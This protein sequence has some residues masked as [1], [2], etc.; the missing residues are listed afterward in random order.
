ARAGVFARD[1]RNATVRSGRGPLEEGRQRAR[2]AHAMQSRGEF[3]GPRAPRRPV[4]RCG[5]H[6]GPSAQPARTGRHP[7][8]VGDGADMTVHFRGAIVALTLSLALGAHAQQPAPT[9]A[10]Q[11]TPGPAP[12]APQ[13]SPT[14]HTIAVPATLPG[15]PQAT[16]PIPQPRPFK[17]VVAGAREMPGFFT[18]YEKDEKVWIEVKPEQLNTPYYLSINRTRGLGENFIYPFMVR[19]YV[20]EFRKV[21]SLVQL[22][23]KNPRYGAKEA[24]P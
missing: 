18:L 2:R 15:T 8:N 22:I 3:R 6:G 5:D 21:G 4:H 11:P 13:A 23:A 12:S 14:Q 10:P 19:G 9:P 7:G 16:P 20:V 1:G 17:D 24:T